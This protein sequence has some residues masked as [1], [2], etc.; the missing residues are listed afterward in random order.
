MTISPRF[1]KKAHVCSLTQCNNNKN[2]GEWVLQPYRDTA[3]HILISLPSQVFNLS[4]H[5]VRGD[6]TPSSIDEPVYVSVAEGQ[7]ERAVSGLE[8]PHPCSGLAGIQEE[9]L[10]AVASYLTNK[11]RRSSSAHC[12]NHSHSYN[13]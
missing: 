4:S 13:T 11:S 10:S 5:S 6:Q 9:F 3:N 7:I 2:I 1:G 12:H 8:H